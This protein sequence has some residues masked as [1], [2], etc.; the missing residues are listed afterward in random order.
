MQ[1]AKQETMTKEELAYLIKILW[2]ALLKESP[3]GSRMT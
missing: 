3:H 1:E 2:E